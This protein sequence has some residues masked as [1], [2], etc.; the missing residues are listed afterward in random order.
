MIYLLTP[1]GGRPEA[2]AMLAGY[3]NAQTFEGPARWVVVDDCDPA[4][5][6]PPVRAGIEVEVIR[7]AWRWQPGMNT[8]AAS[9]TAALQRV[10]AEA[11]VAVLED[12]DAYLPGHLNSVLAAL[13]Q[14]EL[15]GERVARYYN[16]ATQR[17][18]E[19]P[20]HFHA[21]LASTAARGRALALLREVCAAGSRRI[22]MDLWQA[23]R[24]P[25]ALLET[26]NVVGIKGMPG[27]G[28]IGVG[29]RDTFGGPDPS[30]QVL[31]QWL[32][33][34]A[35]AYRGFRRVHG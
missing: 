10:P 31:A 13:A 34:A 32:G 27:R 9:M 14:A 23:F 3:L 26:A 25:R 15:V 16:V 6:V 11:T 22:D 33:P 1:T 4:T 30:G 28:G 19:L 21:S 7:P 20:G 24:G 29:H 8:Q 18:R 5:P 2:L 12:D 17:F 35:E